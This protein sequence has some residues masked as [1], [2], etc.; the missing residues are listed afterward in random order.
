MLTQLCFLSHQLSIGTEWLHQHAS[1]LLKLSC[2]LPTWLGAWRCL[3]SRTLQTWVGVQPS[4]MA[5][6]G[7]QRTQHEP[8]SPNC[9]STYKMPDSIQLVCFSQTAK[10]WSPGME[11]TI[12]YSLWHSPVTTVILLFHLFS[13]VSTICLRA[14][15]N[16]KTIS[17]KSS[18]VWWP[19]WPGIGL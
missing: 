9:N 5:Q 14:N 1:F 7:K 4:V 6:I 17:P 15:I 13:L 3:G 2:F 12:S 18:T 11:G 10:T 16:K 8:P 19:G